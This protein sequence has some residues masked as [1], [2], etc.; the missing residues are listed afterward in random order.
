[1]AIVLLLYSC[2]IYFYPLIIVIR[3]YPTIVLILSYQGYYYR[4]LW[5]MRS[6]WLL[7]IVL[8][9]WPP[10][11]LLLIYC[12]MAQNVYYLL[13]WA[14]NANIPGGGGGI[15]M[16]RWLLFYCYILVIFTFTPWLWIYCYM[17]HDVYSLGCWACMLS[18]QCHGYWL[19]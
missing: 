11:C 2:Y 8:L 7:S 6:R 3:R 5:R 14:C 4:Y 16:C 12:Y 9:L 18:I 10:D 17:A 13:C 19:L 15:T 1:M